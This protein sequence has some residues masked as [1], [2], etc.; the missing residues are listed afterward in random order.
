[1]A[2]VYRNTGVARLT[3]FDQ[4]DVIVQ[5]IDAA[6]PPGYHV[7]WL[8][9]AAAALTPGQWAVA[10]LFLDAAQETAERYEPGILNP[11]E[12][13]LVYVRVSP[14]VGQGQ[15]MQ[16]NL[17][18]ANGCGASLLFT[19]NIP[20]EL[21]VNAGLSMV[22]G[23]TAVLSPTALEATDVDNP[24]AELIYT[25]TVSPAQGTLSPVDG[26]SQEAINNGQV[27]YTHTGLGD[28]TFTFTVSD[29]ADTIGEFV[30]AITVTNAA[31]ELATNTGL[32]VPV[33]ETAVIGFSA[34]ETTDAN[35]PPGELIY[36]VTTPPVRGLLT[37]GTTFSQADITSG[38]VS[39]AH[40]GAGSDSF[41]FTVTDGE[42]TI[43]PY[44]FGITTP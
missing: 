8:P 44:T 3:D 5:Y 18:T 31:P 1:V 38:L 42:F 21:A 25:V 33:G 23:T 32:S 24:P 29:G 35:N 22:S 26:F 34:L 6:D 27:T 17:V 4:W 10:G 14:P 37:P 43:G 7:L 12:E 28:D 40:T 19:R 36:T 41:A 2:L 20:P 16:V 13:I 11:G 15:T 39:Y 30:F 9:Y